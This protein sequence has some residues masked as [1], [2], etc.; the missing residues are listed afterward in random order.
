MNGRYTT[1]FTV[2]AGYR[3]FPSVQKAGNLLKRLFFH[4]G[5]QKLEE[6]NCHN[7]S[8]PKRTQAISFI[9]LAREEFE[10]LLHVIIHTKRIGFLE[11]GD[12]SRPTDVIGARARV[13]MYSC[14]HLPLISCDAD[15]KYWVLTRCPWHFPH[16]SKVNLWWQFQFQWFQ[17]TKVGIRVGRGYILPPPM[18]MRTS[19]AD[20]MSRVP[21]IRLKTFVGHDFRSSVD[22]CFW[23]HSTAL[24]HSVQNVTIF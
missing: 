8:Y 18:M 23:V 14:M 2:R 22:P 19:R 5:Y 24:G 16:A 1:E 20:L 4:F 13:Y 17:Q 12:S 11:L 7:R 6:I 3:V 10:K 21:Y 9:F 15:Q